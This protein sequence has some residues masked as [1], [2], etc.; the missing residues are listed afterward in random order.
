MFTP[1]Q[2]RV[3]ALYRQA[4]RT[5]LDWIVFRDQWEKYCAQLRG[6]FEQNRGATMHDA[7][8]IVAD[9]E[10]ELTENLHPDPY[11]YIYQPGGSKYMRYHPPPPEIIYNRPTDS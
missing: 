11:K 5:S 3:M 9:G 10:K 2:K 6:R 1:H 7:V 4:R 8:K